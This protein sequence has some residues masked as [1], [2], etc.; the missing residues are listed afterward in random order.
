LKRLITEERPEA[1]F[2]DMRGM[3]K[4]M[5]VFYSVTLWWF[6]KKMLKHDVIRDLRSNGMLL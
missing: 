6:P 4:F 1:R 5:L 3:K 2:L